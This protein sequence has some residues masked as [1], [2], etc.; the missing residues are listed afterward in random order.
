MARLIRI[1]CEQRA[2]AGGILTDLRTGK[3]A[4]FYRG[5]AVLVELSLFANGA[6]VPKADISNIK[7]RWRSGETIFSE[8]VIPGAALSPAIT[9]QQWR[10]GVATVAGITYSAE[11]TGNLP[12]GML[13]LEVLATVGA[14]EAIFT[15][16]TIEAVTSPGLITGTPPTPG[17][18]TAYT[19]AQTDAALAAITANAFGLSAGNYFAS[20]QGATETTGAVAS[21]SQSLTV[22]NP[23]T[24][25]AGHGIL[26]KGAGVAGAHLITGIT[27][28]SGSIITLA[29]AA[30][31]AVS[32][33][34]VRH[35]DTAA[36]NAVFAAVFNDGAGIAR[37][38]NGHYRCAGP[39]DPVTNSILKIPQETA[40]T[41]VPRRI[42][43]EGECRGRMNA[44]MTAPLPGGVVFDFSDAP[45][46]S[47]LRPSAFATRAYVAN[48]NFANIATEWNNAHVC[49]DHILW[50]LPSNPQFSGINLWNCTGAEIGAGITVGARADANGGGL[51]TPG[52]IEPTNSASTGI[53]MPAA[54]NNIALYCGPCQIFGMWN[55]L[56]PGEHVV[57]DRPYIA[58]CKNGLYQKL[59]G[60]L[61][62]GRACV[63]SCTYFFSLASSGAYCSLD[64]TIEY[65]GNADTTKWYALAAGGGFYDFANLARG[66][67]RVCGY[68]FGH[69]GTS[70]FERPAQ[71]TGAANVLF[72]NLRTYGNGYASR[73]FAA[74]RPDT[75]GEAIM[76]FNTGAT[77]DQSIGLRPGSNGDLEI[78]S[79][80]IGAV[81][82]RFRKSDG[83]IQALR[84]YKFADE[85]AAPGP[86]NIGGG[87]F[88]VWRNSL[89]SK[90]YL[91]ANFG[92]TVKK[93]ELV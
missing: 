46:A 12:A 65:E 66:V 6:L 62:G 60:H 30:S 88:Q 48:P 79:Y 40:Y 32:G 3:Q 84:G 54:L 70:D 89:D 18:P 67:V 8:T 10:Q 63:E 11:A 23:A 5:E 58:Y 39:F 73:L 91:C 27:A 17:P 2:R 37:I 28:V 85:A 90:I 36:L 9:A 74:T 52:F 25:A 82:A 20:G 71:I 86:S 72:H 26:V 68:D 21:G 83:Q 57:M 51:L 7:V 61:V 31:T 50:V 55:G 76:A 1:E 59:A 43:L 78:Y 92:G 75:A 24:F 34:V 4:Y 41:G 53:I 64:L 13:T 44:D 45:A 29:T 69:S 19:K 49:L 14:G 81:G 93:I 80:G 42:I 87:S 33:A 16:G 56:E 47:G 77:T 35:D 22:A 15:S 38:K